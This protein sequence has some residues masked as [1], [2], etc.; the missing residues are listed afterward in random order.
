MAQSESIQLV[1]LLNQEYEHWFRTIKFEFKNRLDSIPVKRKTALEHNLHHSLQ[2]VMKPIYESEDKDGVWRRL[3]NMILYEDW[4]HQTVDLNRFLFVNRVSCKVFIGRV[5][6]GNDMQ[7]RSMFF[8]YER[9]V[10]EAD[11]KDDSTDT[12]VAIP[13]FG[14]MDLT[15]NKPFSRL[16]KPSSLGLVVHRISLI[17]TRKETKTETVEHV[18]V[19]PKTNMEEVIR[20]LISKLWKP[21]MIKPYW[22]PC[23]LKL[24]SLLN[25]FCS[26]FEMLM[27]VSTPQPSP[28][29]F[30]IL[31]NSLACSA[32]P[33]TSASANPMTD[34]DSPFSNPP[35]TPSSFLKLSPAS[36]FL[37]P[38]SFYSSSL[39]S[40]SS[41]SRSY[42][43][44]SPSKDPAPS[45][46][47][48]VTRPISFHI[49]PSSKTIS[50]L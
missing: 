43:A 22:L 47:T 27:N 19:D 50:F 29:F 30:S 11:Y 24:C 6:N 10:N 1:D 23:I 45:S 16:K 31:P 46:S 33:A 37:S 8:Q 41:C 18:D 40:S 38:S 13:A 26:P 42:S 14:M 17:K 44:N 48:L 36:A 34:G 49:P 9:Y 2:A 20:K 5:L 4:I 28:S 39:H 21:Q 32:S 3:D 12:N 25:E 35:F 15:L 7:T